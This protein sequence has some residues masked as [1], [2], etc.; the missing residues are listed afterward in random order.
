VEEKLQRLEAEIAVFKASALREMESERQRMQQAGAEEAARIL[1][2][3]RA[4]TEIAVRGGKLELQN[5]A[6][7]KAVTLAEDLIRA[8]L[9]DAGRRRLVTQFAASLESKDWKN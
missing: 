9:D 7:Q 1:E 5:Y 2:S 3:A 4:Q 8:R 6:A